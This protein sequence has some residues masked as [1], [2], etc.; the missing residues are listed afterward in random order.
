[1]PIVKADSKGVSLTDKQKLFCKYYLISFNGTKAAIEAGYSKK[2]AYSIANELLKKKEIQEYLNSQKNEIFKK[3]DVT[4]E[5]VLQEIGRIAFSDIRKLYNDNGSL[6]TVKDI[7]DDSAACIAA[8]EVFEEFSG[9][10][11]DREH[12]GNTVKVKLWSKEKGLEM[13]AKHFDIYSDAPI[14]NNE[15]YV[16]YGKEEE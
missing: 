15:V 6:R 12:I 13:L 2:T 16:G 10:G 11:E 7:E 8:V 3:V 1:M 5:R 9:R 14:V 4:K